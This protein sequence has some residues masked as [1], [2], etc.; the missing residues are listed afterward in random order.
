MESKLITLETLE[1]VMDV[2]A[3]MNK[4]VDY[5]NNQWDYF[6]D[7]YIFNEFK[8]KQLPYLREMK[9]DFERALSNNSD[10]SYYL[11]LQYLTNSTDNLIDLISNLV[12]VREAKLELFEERKYKSFQPNDEVLSMIDNAEKKA[13]IK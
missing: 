9:N 7:D 3:K 8:N 11:A 12:Y 5:V 6:S 4:A 13:G 10:N 2:A 1:T